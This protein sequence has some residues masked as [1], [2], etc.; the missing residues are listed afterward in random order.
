MKIGVD[1][2]WL[3]N[4]HISGKLFVQNMLPELI[5]LHPEIDWHVF[6]NKN[7]RELEHPFKGENVHV[8]YVWAGFNMLSNLFVLPKY[9]RRLNLDAVLFQ[10]FSPKS[11]S[12]KSVAFIHDVLFRSY[13][14]Y[15][16]WLERLYFIPL[17]WTARRADRIITT[18][19]FVKQELVTLKYSTNDAID[20]APSGV[21]PI[22]QPQWQLSSRVQEHVREKFNLPEQYVLFV[23]RFNERKNIAGI[24][25][26]L[27]LLDETISLVIVGEQDWKLPSMKNLSRHKNVKSRVHF[28]GAVTDNELACIYASA[29]LF[30]FP[31]FAEGFGLPPLEAMAAGIPVIVSN[32]TAMP[33]VCSDVPLFVDPHNARDI[34]D[35]INYLLKNRHVR[36]E[37]IQQGLRWSSQ[38]TWKRTAEGIMK[39]IFAAIE[40]TKN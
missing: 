14:Q 19:Q 5:A 15:F 31:S 18:T 11:K 33:E 32:T 34:A 25:R 36:E 3:F 2:K 9:A 7:T 23:G 17:K 29:K 28:I 27:P 26:A 4:G 40:T 21:T 39:S 24:I 6:L 38:Y 16:S 10:T 22:F 37:K 35:K 8:H 30:C 12:F 1:A 13:P 20:L